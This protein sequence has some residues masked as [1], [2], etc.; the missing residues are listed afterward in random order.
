MM[1]NCNQLWTR[2]IHVVYRVTRKDVLTPNP[3]ASAAK[4]PT[5]R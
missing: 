5:Q 2:M 4:Q 3:P 1:I